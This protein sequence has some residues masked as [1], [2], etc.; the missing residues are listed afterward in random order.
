MSDIRLSVSASLDEDVAGLF[1]PVVPA[2]ERYGELSGQAFARGFQRGA[3]KS[4]AGAVGGGTGASPGG[5]SGTGGQSQEQQEK[6]KQSRQEKSDAVAA[7]RKER[8]A[9]RDAARAEADQNRKFKAEVSAFN[10]VQ[11][12][13]ERH[14]E[15][16]RSNQEKKAREEKSAQQRKDADAARSAK[17]QEADANKLAADAKRRAKAEENE[18]EAANRR[19]ARREEY[20]RKYVDG[21]RSRSMLQEQR[22]GEREDRKKERLQNRNAAIE[23][24]DSRSFG[25]RTSYSAARTFERL[26]TSGVRYASDFARSAGVQ[27]DLG[28]AVGKA[29]DLRKMASELSNS[30]Y[31][32]GAKGANGQRTNARELERLARDTGNMAGFDASETLGGLKDY[33]G[34]TGDLS[35]GRELLKEMAVLAK[36]TGT[37]LSDMISAAGDAANAIDETPGALAKGE[38]K[39]AKIAGLMRTI[40][41][42]GKLGAV[43]IS[44]LATQMAKLSASSMAFDGDQVANLADMGT[45]VQM[46]RSKGGASSATGAATSVASFVNLIK[47]PARMKEYEKATGEKVYN[48]DTGKFKSVEQIVLSSLKATGANPEALKK[49][50]ANV[51]GERAVAGFATTYRDAGGGEA[52]LTAVKAEFEKYRKIQMGQGEIKDSFNNRMADYDSQVTLFNNK[53]AEVGA[54]LAERMLPQLNAIAPSIIKVVGSFGDL[55]AW[56]AQN[57]FRAV[58]SAL[59]VSIMKAGIESVL[60]SGIESA[61]KGA[62]SPG[63]AAALSGGGVGGAGKAAVDAA[64]GGAGMFPSSPGGTMGKA[65]AAAGAGLAITATAITIAEVGMMAIDKVFKQKEDA[66]SRALAVEIEASNKNNAAK[67]EIEKARLT[68]EEQRKNIASLKSQ[69]RHTEAAEAEMDLMLGRTTVSK[70]TYGRLQQNK[71]DIDRRVEA[72]TTGTL[73]EDDPFTWLS[74]RNG[75]LSEQ[76]AGGLSGALSYVTAGEHGTSFDA[77]SM[78]EASAAK[79]GELKAEQQRTNEILAGI[80]VAAEKGG[81]GTPTAPTAGTTAITP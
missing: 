45:L 9:K 35:T 64:K 21:V 29:V 54:T 15:Q 27:L 60:R 62:F 36:A 1:K 73:R 66:E 34:K 78:R 44:N 59:G 48:E 70:E 20:L 53:I 16:E 49:I 38:S 12:I 30:A 46:A 22:A 28:G 75:L 42:Q 72:G 51:Q 40:A 7:A 11:R 10:Y 47:T 52:G 58:V 65:L 8:D 50:F 37:D 39:A 13:R 41:G 4:I 18:A 74:R 68:P 77:Q 67:A 32:P 63:A 31:M 5:R 14:F 2:A 55:V 25:Q 71:A 3:G 69:G 33:V 43:E 57:P 17:K 19:K 61:L 80:K 81:I 56:A 6:Q 24:R 76:L 23:E 79:I 26:S